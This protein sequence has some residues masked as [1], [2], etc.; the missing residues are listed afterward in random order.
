[1]DD[2]SPATWLQLNPKHFTASVSNNSLLNH[3]RSGGI[4]GRVFCVCI[5]AHGQMRRRSGVCVIWPWRLLDMTLI[6]PIRCFRHCVILLLRRRG[7]RLQCFGAYVI[8]E[9]SSLSLA[10]WALSAQRCTAVLLLHCIS[11][12]SVWP[13][14]CVPQ[15][16][17]FT[18]QQAFLIGRRR[19]CQIWPIALSLFC[20]A[21][22]TPLMTG[23]ESCLCFS[24]GFFMLCLFDFFSFTTPLRFWLR[25]VTTFVCD[26]IPPSKKVLH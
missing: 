25:K 3:I 20:A 13:C 5:Y 4:Y 21:V 23:R 2:R 6:L 10:G 19:D 7:Q 18:S 24:G 16:L 9:K 17:F 26:V 22:W 11:A 1:M 8:W 15:I 12:C 14:R